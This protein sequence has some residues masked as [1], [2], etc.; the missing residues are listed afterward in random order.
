MYLKF[1]IAMNIIKLKLSFV[2][3]I[4]SSLILTISTKAETFDPSQADTTSIEKLEKFCMEDNDGNACCFAGIKLESGKDCIQDKVKAK[5]LYSLGCDLG[6]Q[7][8][9][10]ALTYLKNNIEKSQ[11]LYKISNCDIYDLKTCTPE[12]REKIFITNQIDLTNLST[13]NPSQDA[14]KAYNL[15]KSK[16]DLNSAHL[17]LDKECR[18]NNAFACTLK[19][20]LIEEGTGTKSDNK[21][22]K[23]MYIAACKQK[24][25][26]A[27]SDLGIIYEKE[28]E[29]EQAKKAYKRGCDL[30]YHTACFKLGKHFADYNEFKESKKY[31]ELACNLHNA[32]ACYG[33]GVVLNNENYSEE[34]TDSKENPEKYFSVSCLLGYQQGCEEVVMRRNHIVK[35]Q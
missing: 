33:L 34:E 18:N 6:D 8:S 25:G 29:I 4:F 10:T 15:I 3:F 1:E 28:W 24:E 12:E 16:H 23:Q 20:E 30:N 26:R 2:L 5:Q 35:E 27:C 19:A 17:L 14:L 9:C 7:Y 13:T 21:K 11:K 32:Q 31:L 22:A